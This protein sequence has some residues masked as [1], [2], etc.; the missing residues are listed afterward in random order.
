MRFAS[1][2]IAAVVFAVSTLALVEVASAQC[3]RG[4]GLILGR[5]SARVERRMARRSYFARPAVAVHYGISPVQAPS[6]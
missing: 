3:A 2:I 4:P 6:K 1:I 5:R